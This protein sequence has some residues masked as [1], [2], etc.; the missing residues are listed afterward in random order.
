VLELRDV[1][2]GGGA[3]LL[4]DAAGRDG[5][6]T[7]RW[8][9]SPGPYLALPEATGTAEAALAHVSSKLLGDLRRQRR[10]LETDVS[11][12]LRLERIARPQR[13]DLERF[14]DLE[15]SG[16]KGA[17]GT[18]IACDPAT[19]SFYDQVAESAA[20]FGYF[21]LYSLD[22]GGR[23]LAMH[24]GLEHNGR[25]HLLKPA[26]DESFRTYSPGNLIV[27]EVVR[28]AVERGLREVDLMTDSEPWKTRWSTGDRHF[29]DCYVFRGPARW[30]LHAWKFRAMTAARRLKHRLRPA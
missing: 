3:E 23:R 1:P 18:A 27:E 26:F 16:W 5:C 20:G 14:Y 9:L 22:S 17:E 8:E 2:R 29:C 6:P 28:D 12:P 4:L 7:G 10:K 30:A 19:R 13:T 21:S 25:F 11:E 15:R 24:Y